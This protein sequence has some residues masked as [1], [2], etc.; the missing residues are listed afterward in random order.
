MPPIL[1]AAT[2]C[3]AVHPLHGTDAPR[4]LHNHPTPTPIHPHP[5]PLEAFL[6][7]R[8]ARGSFQRGLSTHH[9]VT[10]VEELQER[11]DNPKM[12][13]RTSVI[14]EAE[15]DVRFAV[16]AAALL[17]THLADNTGNLCHK[18]A[19]VAALCEEYS[20][21]PRLPRRLGQASPS[22]RSTTTS[23]RGERAIRGRD[24]RV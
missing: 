17:A 20:L 9:N 11:H 23:P 1:T 2:P 16:G 22:S 13:M 18:T 8:R 21:I 19:S 7:Q 3:L 5:Q 4:H 12:D 24:G 6:D 10:S 14:F 15:L